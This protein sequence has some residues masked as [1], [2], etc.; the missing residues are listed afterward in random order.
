MKV[1]GRSSRLYTVYIENPRMKERYVMLVKIPRGCLTIYVPLILKVREIIVFSR[2][3]HI[4]GHFEGF[5]ERTETLFD[6]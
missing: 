3:K 1:E 2:A 6:P 4:M 5:F